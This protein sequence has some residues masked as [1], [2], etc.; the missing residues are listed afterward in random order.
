[1]GKLP[2]KVEHLPRAAKTLGSIYVSLDERMALLYV[3]GSQWTNIDEVEERLR[4]CPLL[5]A[6]SIAAP[7]KPAGGHR[8]DRNIRFRTKLNFGLEIGFS[9]HNDKSHKSDTEST[10]A[11]GWVSWCDGCTTIA[12]KRR[13]LELLCSVMGYSYVRPTPAAGGKCWMDVPFEDWDRSDPPEQ[14]PQAPPPGVTLLELRACSTTPSVTAAVAEPGQP[15]AALPAS[16]GPASSSS[17]PGPA[18]SSSGPQPPP[19]VL[20]AL[21]PKA[22]PPPPT[23]AGPKHPPATQ[24]NFPRHQRGL[25]K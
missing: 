13:G 11:H 25:D 3:P 23:P 20:P 22:E 8:S 18:S 4:Q 12:D 2:Y 1:M 7:L 24:E 17:G 19:P 21:Q 5:A 6:G 14:S 10:V 15:L 16:A 9:I